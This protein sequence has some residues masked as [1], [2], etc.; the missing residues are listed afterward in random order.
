VTA[1][2]PLGDDGIS[3]VVTVAIMGANDLGDHVTGTVKVVLPL[4]DE[5]ANG[6]AASDQG[7]RA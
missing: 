1:K 2:G 3:G 5:S 6:S 4:G 7:G